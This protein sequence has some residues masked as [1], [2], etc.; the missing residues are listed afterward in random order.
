VRPG[1]T[2]ENVILTKKQISLIAV[3]G[4]S[5]I[6]FVVDKLLL[7]SG[8]PEAAR[9]AVSA[10]RPQLPAAPAAKS[11]SAAAPVAAAPVS[12]APATAKAAGAPLVFASGA[13]PVSLA[14]RLK[15]LA[16]ADREPTSIREAF[17]PS[18]AWLAA[19]EDAKPAPPAEPAA[20]PAADS[21]ADFTR[22]HKLTSV[23]RRGNAGSAIVDGK[24]IEIGEQVD[25][26][27]LIGLTAES[28][29]FRSPRQAKEVKL[30]IAGAAK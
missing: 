17:A 16:L 15:S 26:Y 21:T 7:D 12:A 28:A 3:L 8:A 6:G 24:F 27:R 13:T 11:V 29:V 4:T 18:S 2:E 22:Q 10:S 20:A 25:G 5:V 30:F 19:L 23:L 1:A 14:D 9:A